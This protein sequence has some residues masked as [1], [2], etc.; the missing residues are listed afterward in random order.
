MTFSLFLQEKNLLRSWKIWNSK[1]NHL[2]GKLPPQWPEHGMHSIF[3]TLHFPHQIFPKLRASRAIG[4]SADIIYF[5]YIIPVSPE[6]EMR[7]GRL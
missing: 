4:A 5:M 3:W 2:P 6:V 1:D 7:R